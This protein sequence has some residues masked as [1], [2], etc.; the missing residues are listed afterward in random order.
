MAC[1]EKT[2]LPCCDLP[3]RSRIANEVVSAVIDVH[4][5]EPEWTVIAEPNAGTLECP[6]WSA[7]ERLLYW[8]DIWAPNLHACNPFDDS[9]APRTWTLPDPIGCFSV[10]PDDVLLAL[11]SGIVRLD[12]SSGAITRL[13]PAPYPTDRL[14]FNDG[15]C[16]AKGRM[17]VGTVPRVLGEH[18]PRGSAEFW[19]IDADGQS[20][21]IT[22]LSI[23]NG[24]AF[25]PAGDRFYFSDGPSARIVVLDY[26][27]DSGSAYNPRIFA[28][29]DPGSGPDGAT[30][31]VD[32][33][34][35]IA[36]CQAGLIVRYRPD[37]RVDRTLRAPTTFPTMV[38]FGG[39]DLRTM[40]VTTGTRAPRGQAAAT[41]GAVYAADVGT[42]GLPEPPHWPPLPADGCQAVQTHPVV[43]VPALNS[44][45]RR[46]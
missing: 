40:F 8:E 5:E 30:V 27:L 32:G 1:T 23:A 34:Y 10:G 11:S 17:W 6:R 39:A 20:P 35:W 31:D 21:A 29:V 12:R 42:S 9:V 14:R 16:D 25:S 44:P 45:S 33:G 37:G 13:H 36:F 41:T 18:M 43:E 7:D 4:V 19:R 46:M 2:P 22:G 15:R 3:S 26:D 24:S 38:T 28:S